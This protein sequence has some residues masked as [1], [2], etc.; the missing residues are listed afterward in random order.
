MTVAIGQIDLRDIHHA[1]GAAAEFEYEVPGVI[2]IP[3]SREPSVMF[4]IR[5][6]V[7][8]VHHP[9]HPFTVP[10]RKNLRKVGFGHHPQST[11]LTRK[12]EL[13]P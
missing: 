10:P 12:H 8:G 11:I 6:Q 4:L 5:D 1:H 9:S 13:P 3:G 7:V 2:P